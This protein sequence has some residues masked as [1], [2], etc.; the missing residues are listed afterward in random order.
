[1]TTVEP[2]LK[3]QKI[4][5]CNGIE[6]RNTQNFVSHSKNIV[7]VTNVEKQCAKPYTAMESKQL[8]DILTE[9]GTGPLILS[10]MPFGEDKKATL[11]GI[12]PELGNAKLTLFKKLLFS[13]K[14]F[15]IQ[16][17]HRSR[18]ALYEHSHINIPCKEYNDLYNKEQQYEKKYEKDHNMVDWN[19]KQKL[20]YKKV[21]IPKEYRWGARFGGWGKHR[22]G[23]TRKKH[24]R[25]SYG[26]YY[27]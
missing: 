22:W 21:P 2:A 4:V 12:A 18:G 16:W 3:K 5:T 10:R 17:T 11:L 13:H 15:W 7:R 25:Y 1:M 27:P 20:A 14:H 26:L 19:W 23:N 8:L 6:S 24:F 9:E